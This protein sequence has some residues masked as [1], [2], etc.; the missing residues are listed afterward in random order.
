MDNF[1]PD[2]RILQRYLRNECTP[3][4]SEAVLQWLAKEN[5]PERLVFF[6]Q[7]LDEET[8]NAGFS[9]EELQTVLQKSAG[10]I[11]RRIED[12][13]G[14]ARIRK[15]SWLKLSA[16]AAVLICLSLSAWL[17]FGHDTDAV[18]VQFNNKKGAKKIEP[19]GDKA[20]LTLANG[21]TVVLDEAGNGDLA[22]QGNAKV[23]KLNGQL[24]Y[25]Q[26]GSTKAPA[27]N[28]I[29]TPRGGQYKLILAD[30]TKV[31]LNA[32]SS[33]RFPVSFSGDVRTVELSGEGYFEVAAMHSSEHHKK[34]PFLVKILHAAGN[35]GE[36]EVLGTHF[37]I[38][39]YADEAAVKTTL[40]EGSVR[41]KNSKTNT[42]LQPGEQASLQK[43]TL[44]VQKRVDVEEVI[45][46]KEGYFQFD[47]KAPIEQVMR[48]VARWYDVEIGYEGA[49]PN[50]RFGGKIAR[51]SR[52]QDVLKMLELNN[53]RFRIEG[54][55]ITVTP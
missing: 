14:G 47:R 50:R 40:L 24:S 19:G 35:T 29:T 43:E 10:I 16:A 38:M 42:L 28:T 49:I 4:E 11:N 15:F 31:W 27:Y 30:G 13:E 41:I 44:E 9:E 22:Q 52:L 23:I 8:D 53:I 1:T 48:Q 54:R 32:A 17:W 33:L 20:V 3:E 45:A 2:N 34:I 37:N 6:N 46:W 55:K 26:T 39:A 51:D 12:N 18:A 7:L 36:V 25:Q 21:Q 5:D